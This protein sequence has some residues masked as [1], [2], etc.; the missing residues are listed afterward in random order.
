[1][2][3]IKYSVYIVLAVSWTVFQSWFP[4]IVPFWVIFVMFLSL[5]ILFDRGMKTQVVKNDS[6]GVS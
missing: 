2:F 5:D 3:Y 6:R 4:D 1:M